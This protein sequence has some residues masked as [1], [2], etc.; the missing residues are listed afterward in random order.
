MTP[1]DF[2]TWLRG[3]AEA[4]N[5]Y[6][7]TPEQWHKM[8]DVLNTVDET[9]QVPSPFNADHTGGNATINYETS[10]PGTKSLLTDNKI[11]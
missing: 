5:Q 2:V 7:I 6:N 4:A 9:I 10:V 1:K 8:R 3:F 11:Y